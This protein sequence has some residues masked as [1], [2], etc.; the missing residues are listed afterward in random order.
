MQNFE[1]IYTIKGRLGEVTTVC[2][3]VAHGHVCAHATC[4]Y[5]LVLTR[6]YVCM[7]VICKR[8]GRCAI[9]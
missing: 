8:H 6:I 7:Q 9:V 1:A 3:Y 5:H 2:Y 4:D